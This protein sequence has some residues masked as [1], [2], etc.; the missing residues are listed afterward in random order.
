MLTIESIWQAKSQQKIFMALLNCMALPGKIVD[1]KDNLGSYSALLG[2]LA[3][4][5]DNTVTWSDEDELVNHRDRTLLATPLVPSNKAQ[6]IVKNATIAPNNHFSPYLGELTSPEQG[7]TLILQ[8]NHLGKGNLK[9]QLSGPGIENTLT[10]SLDQFDP[11][12]FKQRYLWNKHFPL[13]VDMILV[14]QTQILALPRTTH[15]EW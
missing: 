1:L 13:G 15:L 11:E 12:W 14:D 4:L 6:F 9:L 5:L 2:V 7:A 10:I 8:G 3:T